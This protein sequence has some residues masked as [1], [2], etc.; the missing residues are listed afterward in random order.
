VEQAAAAWPLVS[1]QGPADMAHRS[2]LFT[3][4]SRL[5]ETCGLKAADLYLQMTRIDL[6]ALEAAEKL[7][8]SQPE[9]TAVGSWSRQGSAWIDRLFIGAPLEQHLTTPP[10]PLAGL[11]DVRVEFSEK[12]DLRVDK[13]LAELEISVDGQSY[14]SLEQFPGLSADWNPRSVDL[15]AFSGRTVQLRFAVK[16]QQWTND[17]PGEA[18]GIRDL[19][20]KAVR[21]GS[22]VSLDLESLQRSAVE[23][24]AA[25]SSEG[26]TI[27][28][29]LGPDQA[30][31]V[32]GSLGQARALGLLEGRDLSHCLTR[33]LQSM[34][35]GESLDRAL[36]GLLE[37]DGQSLAEHED[38]VIVGG[39]RVGKRR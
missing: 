13:N 2:R 8:R 20:L 31:R 14:T 3:L 4:A 26:L 19:R 6:E 21:E 7:A 37:G 16:P 25:A 28:G 5:A 32:L 15:S 33:V 34:I 17:G 1:S 10:L 27:L 23:M 12:H 9:W 11:R 30:W 36:E 18:L 29:Q 35:V 38:A 39:V 22:E 24:L